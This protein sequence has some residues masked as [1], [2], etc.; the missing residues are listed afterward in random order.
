MTE[1][2][3]FVDRLIAEIR[4]YRD[5]PYAGEPVRTVYF[6]GGTPS[7]LSPA[8]IER[9]LAELDITFDLLLQECT[10]EM[11]PDDVRADY[12][13]ALKTVGINRAS[14]GVQTFDPDLLKFMNRAH[15]REEALRCLELLALADFDTFTVDLIYGNPGQTLNGLRADLDQLL[16]FDPPHVS[17]YSLTVEPRTRLGKQVD[18]GR[19]LP[20]DEDLVADHF[21]LVAERLAEQ[22]ID[23][24]EVSNYS[25]PGHEAVHNSNY[26]RHSNYLGMGPGAH[27]FWWGEQAR[28][29][30][31][32]PSL[33][34]YLEED[35][36]GI[37]EGVEELALSELAEERIM[38]GL[39]TR[40]G[41]SGEELTERYGY[42]LSERQRE[43][44]HLKEREG[45]LVLTE[46]I[47]LTAE[48][49]RI[50]DAIVLD[51]ITLH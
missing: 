6:G 22:G 7:L 21:V 17:A 25:K 38:M 13:R 19:I 43:Y 3:R 50:A 46:E 11:N 29:W 12:L 49:L 28:R 27:S 47:V 24:Y 14:M 36:A 31:N 44:L 33:K 51:L 8:Q 5:T 40:R 45:K 4:S 30:S 1:R 48:G 16:A 2:E 32:K 20:P 10:L 26:W 39:R 35:G 23:R 15:T 42:A 9:I 18:L 37:V 41:L 34:Q